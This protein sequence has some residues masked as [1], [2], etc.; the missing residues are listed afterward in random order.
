[1]AEF[2]HFLDAEPLNQRA[3]ALPMPV[4]LIWGMRDRLVKIRALADYRAER[5]IQIAVVPAAGHLAMI[6]RPAETA[7]LIRQFV[8]SNTAPTSL[9]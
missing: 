8:G 3:A 6:E 2:Q 7:Q 4:L 1:L 5:H 9:P